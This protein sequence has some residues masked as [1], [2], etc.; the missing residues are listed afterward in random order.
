[1]IVSGLEKTI[2]SVRRLP[3]SIGLRSIY[4][5]VC[6]EFSARLRAATPLG[7]SGQ[8]K[9]SVV[10]EA[11]DEQGIVGYEPGVET[12]GDE[13]LDS[14]LRVR[15]RGQSV[16]SKNWVRPSQLEAIF[17]ESLDSYSQEGA[18]LMQ[19]RIADGLS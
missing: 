3:S 1:M 5:E 15:Q 2:D 16:L 17:Q 14:V 9:D 13:R 7:Y 11:S 6:Q 19:S 8:L 4:D 10:Y 12:A 18:A